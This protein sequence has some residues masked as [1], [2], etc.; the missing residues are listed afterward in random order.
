MDVRVYWYPEVP[1]RDLEGYRP[2]VFDVLRATTTMLAALAGGASQI[3]PVASLREAKER[4]RC[5][6][7]GC[8][9]GGE[10]RGLRPPGF[11]LG[12]SPGEYQGAMVAGKTVIITTTNGTRA[13]LAAE[14]LGPP[15]IG[16]LV[17][18]QRLAAGLDERTVVL[19]LAG[20]QGTPAAEDLLGAGYLLDRLEERVSIRADD[21]GRIAL[22]YYRQSAPN[23]TKALQATTAGSR[24]A[25]LGLGADVLYAA[26]RDR[27][28]LLAIYA[29]GAITV[30]S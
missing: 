10:R 13:L 2:V 26:A 8:C 30:V 14:R 9:L 11:H 21:L 25:D 22:A 23:L 27:H 17:N 5:D 24:L 29:A 1:W 3:R 19:V 20:R 12:N 7:K 18:G 16:A 6:P 15:Y 4:Y 28:P